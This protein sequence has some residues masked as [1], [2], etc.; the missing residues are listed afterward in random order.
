MDQQRERIQDDLRGLVAGDV[1]CDDIFLQ[2][3]ASDASIYQIRPLGVVCPRSVAD[4]VASVQYASE[5]EL[6]IHPRG[7]GSGL[8]GE[9]LGPGLVLDFSRYMRRI[10]EI[11]SDRVRVQPG[12]VHAHLNAELS[13]QKRMFGPTPANAAVTT[14]GSVVA[15]D[16]AGSRW[17]R[18]GSA[19]KHVL[20]MQVVLADGSVVNLGR[21]SLGGHDAKTD[22]PRKSKLVADVSDLLLRNSNLIKNHK[23]KS[24]VNRCGYQLDGVLADGH[25]DM[26]KL[27]VGSEGTLGLITEVTL[28][29]LSLPVQTG[30]ALL[31]FDRL[32]NA[33]QA[34]QE[35]LPL[36][37]TVCDLVDRRHCSLARE[38]DVRYDLLIPPTA[39]AVLV[40]ECEGED[41]RSVRDQLVLITER[42]RDE[43]RLA[44]DARHTL[45][46]DEQAFYWELATHV[47]PRLYRLQGSSRP[48]PFVEDIAVPP[49]ALPQMLLEIQNTLKRH[50][51]TAS[52]FAHAGQGQLHLR[53]FLDLAKQED[54]RLLGRFAEDLYA[55]VLKVGGTIS[56]EHGDGLSRSW[57]VRQQ[58]GPLYEVFRELK[59]L[60][61]PEHILNPGKI[62]GS[63]TT[64][65]EQHLR[66]VSIPQDDVPREPD[67]A[68]ADATEADRT[69]ELIP[70]QLDWSPSELLHVARNCNGCGACRTVSTNDRMCPIFHNLPR[71]EA[72]PRAK[73]NLM[74]AVLTGHLERETLAS[75]EFKHVADLCVNCHQCRL[76]CPA[77]VDI[78]KLMVEAKAAH[79]A[80][81]GLS[82]SDWLLSRL[83]LVGK[84]ASAFASVSNWAIRNRQARWAIEKMFGIAQGRKLPSVDRRSFMRRA[85]RAR[86]TK[87]TKGSGRKVV[88]FVDSYAN[89]FDPQLGDALVAVMQHNGVSVYVPPRQQQAGMAMI[90][91]G[92]VARARRL[93]MRNVAILA[94][95]VRQGY[96]IVAT[97]PSAALCLMHEYPGMIDDDEVRLVANN[98][99]E[100]CTYLW[101]MH[102]E[103]KLRLDFNPVN[104]TIGYHTPCHLKALGVGTPGEK[105]LSLIPGLNVLS[106]E[107]GCSGMAGTFGLKRENYRSSLRS[108]WALISRLRE[109]QLQAG[110]TECSTCKIQMEQGTTKPTVHPLK[111][112]A[113]AYGLMPEVGQLL[114][115]R[116]HELMV[117][118]TI[119]LKFFALAKDLAETAETTLDLPAGTTVGE[120]RTRLVEHYPALAVLSAHLTIAI[121]ARYA[122]DA[123]VIPDGSEV[124]CIPPVSGG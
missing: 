36:G 14:M 74:R 87:P 55:Q 20:E 120:L 116:G 115:S 58:Y 18:H 95:C 121:D 24:E 65:P 111:L 122:A 5:N 59:N 67:P 100:A 43:R 102:H 76:E 110:T 85:A 75:D 53:P 48:I 63:G 79:V 49:A 12:V 72:S 41:A 83:D 9:S 93:A 28:A 98:T 69:T 56:G 11:A 1:R 94:E 33:A 25:L 7:A 32:E 81:S 54:I 42:I 35:I 70:L 51:I 103:G 37:V 88:F 101:R 27:L 68:E 2:M 90:S 73:A 114:N 107:T 64:H 84:W 119:Q 50:Q 57:Y 10:V 26:A 124:A 118:W 86:L 23:P 47:V 106:K 19:R 108:G 66:P 78:P 60:F 77:G 34:V 46:A 105:L 62:V 117:T 22:S 112:V 30:V 96:H 109:P 39:E 31:M 52:L 97:E 71:E 89:H 17:L 15:L 21:E 92:A 80:H 6:A 16:A 91:M 38:S 4:V 61:D 113:H 123:E 82:P 104:I 29:T 13:G 44:F 3:Y 8:A 99:S 45:D 40:I